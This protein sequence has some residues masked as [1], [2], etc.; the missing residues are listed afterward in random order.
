MALTLEIIRGQGS[1]TIGVGAPENFV[2]AVTNAGATSVTL[3]SLSVTEG[4]FGG[5]VPSGSVIVGQ[6][7]YLAAGM[8]F[9]SSNPTLSPG[10]TYYYPFQATFTSPAQS[11][12]SPQAPGGSAGSSNA[13]TPQANFILSLQSVSSDATVA[14]AF[15]MVPVLSGIAP[16]PLATGG[17]LQLSQGFNL[18]NLLTSFG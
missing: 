6:P 4:V 12:P 14:S 2:A 16:F 5:T 18:V 9:A 15:L 13:N 7:K 8:P 17:G 10:T 11:G 3:A 1:A